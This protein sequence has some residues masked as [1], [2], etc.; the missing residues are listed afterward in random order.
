[1]NTPRSGTPPESG[2]SSPQ[3]LESAVAAAAVRE[4]ARIALS[5]RRPRVQVPSTPPLPRSGT[6]G[7]PGVSPLPIAG[8]VGS[9]PAPSG[10]VWYKAGTRDRQTFRQTVSA[11]NDKADHT[12]SRRRAPRLPKF[13]R[14]SLRPPFVLT[15]RDGHL[16][17]AVH[18]YGL[19]STV[20]LLSRCSPAATGSTVGS[21]PSTTTGT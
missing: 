2:A 1:M 8:V 5:S 11:E 7:N 20:E 15:E 9:D 10:P 21:A 4:S 13:R 6:P 16:I 17:Q 19:L 14:T 18:D 3:A 12:L